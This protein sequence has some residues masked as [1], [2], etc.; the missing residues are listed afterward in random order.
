VTDRLAIALLAA[1]VGGTACQREVPV[2]LYHA[3]GCGTSDQLDVPVEQF[4]AQLVDAI[5]QGYRFVPLS[6]LVA[7]W[8]QGARPPGATLAL[9]FDDGAGCLFAAA[10]PILQRHRIP[11]TLFLTGDWLGSDPDRRHIEDVN[12][13]TR[14]PSLDWPEVRA[15]VASGLAEVGSHGLHHLYLPRASESEAQAEVIT[16]R[17]MLAEGLGAPVDLFAYP[18]GAFDRASLSLVRSAGYRAAFAVGVGTGGRY[19]YRRRSIHR[20]Q[21]PHDFKS[22]LSTRWIL[23]ILN[24]D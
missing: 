2:L 19:A 15:M 8:E 16:S 23:P 9:T 10:F 12:A 24:H 6:Q 14:W 13:H 22:Q 5:Q 4:E 11:F 20:D 17:L 3:V 21:S 7:G 18:F 1:A